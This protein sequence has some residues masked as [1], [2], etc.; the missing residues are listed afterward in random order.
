MTSARFRMSSGR[1]N[2]LESVY[3]EAQGGDKIPQ[4]QRLN[5]GTGSAPTGLRGQDQHYLRG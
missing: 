1:L 5:G 2:G 4:P 3:P